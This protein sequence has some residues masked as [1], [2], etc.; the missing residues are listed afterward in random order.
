MKKMEIKERIEMKKG[1]PVIAFPEYLLHLNGV[2]R[3]G[4]FV[5]GNLWMPFVVRKKLFLK[6][7]QLYCEVYNA[8]SAE[9]EKAFLNNS[10]NLAK[11][12]LGVSH[13]V[14]VNTAL[15]RSHPDG[16][17]YCKW[18]SYKVDL[19]K[20]EE[21]LFSGLHSK[22][23]NVIRKAEQEGTQV[24]HGKEYAED[25]VALMNDTYGRQGSKYTFGKIY[26]NNI[27]K[28][29]D[30]ADWWV[31]KDKEGNPQGS[32]VF[33][34]NEGASCYYMHGGSAS[35]TSTGAMNYLIWK[36]M[37]TMKER[38]VKCF[39]FVGARL[40]TTPG[41]KLEGI[42]RFKSRFGSTLDQ[43]YMFRYVCS[44][45]YYCIF[46]IIFWLFGKIYHVRTTDIIQEER[47]KGNC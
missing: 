15:F 13:V 36:A 23:R 32:A 16:A 21:E 19:S 7:I 10:I 41:S 12:K 2:E 34:W 29:G 5:E 33:L 25:V 22:H 20:T 45:S 39:D 40:T 38:G 17:D 44:K 6:W 46:Q 35:H 18:G 37:L 8:T 11:E 28:L 24:F 9:E 27:N 3:I 30:H 1:Y 31:V 4:Y 26:I 14:S 43:G 47:E 42:Q